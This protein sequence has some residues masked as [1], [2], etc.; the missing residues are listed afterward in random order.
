M[1]NKKKFGF[2]AIIAVIALAFALTACILPE[3]D[4]DD[5]TDFEYY[6]YNGQ[7]RIT[8]YV[9]EGGDVTIP[10]KIGGKP[11]TEIS[12]WL[13]Y[14]NKVITS[15]TLGNHVTS[16]DG[17]TGCDRLTSITIPARVTSIWPYAC[18]NCTGLTSVTFQGTIPRSGWGVGGRG[19][20]PIFPGNLGGMFYETDGDNGTPGTYT[21]PSG[22]DTWTLQE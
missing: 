13:F 22:S 7:I 20:Y 8:K 16:L 5:V 1:K 19:W 14:S 12:Q 18:E 10:S 4:G 2:T 11:V 9:G 17:F 3:E 15:V 21:R 6:E